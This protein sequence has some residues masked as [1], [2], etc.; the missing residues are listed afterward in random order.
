[1]H[2][3]YAVGMKRPF[4]RSYG[5]SL[6]IAVLA[7]CPYVV[8]TTAYTLYQQQIL[9]QLGTGRLGLEII[10]GLATAGYAFGA[11]LGG[12]LATRFRQRRLFLGS[13]ALFIAGSLLCATAHQV[14]SYGAGRVLQGFATGVLLVVALPPVIRR[15]PPARLP[16]TVTFV[17]L[18]F[19]GA[20][21]LGPLVGGVVGGTQVW[22]WFYA[23]LGGIGA[24]ILV[25]STLTLPDED[26]PNPDLPVD[27]VGL[28]LGLACTVLPF[29]AVG[30]LQGQGF[31][32]LW[33]QLPL[34]VGGAC[35][36][37]LL[38]TEYHQR[39]PLAPV[40]R[41]WSTYPLVGTLVAM[42][43]G[44]VY[45]TLVDLHTQALLQVDQ[46][47]PLPAG[48]Q[49][50]P[51]VLGVLITASLLGV[52]LRTRFLPLLIGGG[53]M[54]LCAGGGLL[55][56]PSSQSAGSLTS[57]AGI[58]LLGLGAGATVSPGLF[59]AGLSLKASIIGRVL[60]L[61]ELVRSIADFLIAP[62]LLEVARVSSHAAMLNAAGVR[63]AVW[64]SLLIGIASLASIL[65]LYLIG[66][67]DLPRPDIA[68]WLTREQLAI[69]SPPLGARLRGPGGGR[70]PHG[71][72]PGRRLSGSF[73]HADPRGPHRGP[74]R[75]PH[76]P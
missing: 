20:V 40:K 69:E 56:L 66:S 33:F 49:Y 53:M 54:A 23:G 14:L 26:P 29:L 61:V 1:M 52:L 39:E 5:L 17:N 67:S 21:A 6:T 70:R 36:V 76:D 43:A 28:S 50:W 41:M 48:W 58:G 46:L 34:A 51:Q 12:D 8:V 65:V 16:L 31:H 62:I 30:E 59:L 24:L 10:A 27:W 3:P 47:K 57:L 2:L 18:G 44:G 72:I 71:T 4:E 60:A 35:L 75:H 25:L 37:A 11:L 7:L 68:G 15:F 42:L 55:C 64:V 38:L 32:S 74:A 45:V 22:R 63:T 73:S 13:E 19:F 9:R